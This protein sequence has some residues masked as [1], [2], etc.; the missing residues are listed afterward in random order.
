MQ[1]AQAADF[2]HLLLR[3][4][5]EHPALEQARGVRIGGIGEDSIRADDQGAAFGRI[6]DLDRLA[7]FFQQEQI[8]FVAV[9]HDGALAEREFFRR[10]GR[11]LHLQHVL[12]RELLEIGPAEI[13]RHLIRR[14]ENR[15]AI[16]RVPLHD[17]SVP[18][19]IEEVGK[20][21]RRFLGLH[22]RR[23]VADHAQPSAPG[24]E[25]P[26]RVPVFRRIMTRDI[27]G[28]VRREP[29]VALPH[30]EM[31][32][33]GGIH[34]IDRINSAA[35]FLADALKYALGARALDARGD[36]GIFRFERF[37]DLFRDRQ[38]YRGVPGDLAFLAGR[39]DQRGR[40]RTCL[41][42]CRLQRRGEGAERERRR[43]FQ[44]VPPGK[45]S[46]PH[47]RIL[48]IRSM[49]G[50]VPAANAARPPSPA[51][52]FAPPARPRAT[53]FRPRFRRH[54]RDGRRERL[55]E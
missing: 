15:S 24:R 8:I 42:R 46:V 41:G 12:L 35:V 16:A 52:Y 36:A 28:N 39:L 30:D 51:R 6:D 22:Q 43:P 13:A 34:D 44:Q 45:F 10:L 48:P 1:R 50:S 9:G 38:I 23:V 4:D 27:L 17:L 19:R 3:L 20:A 31:R 53:A 47:R 40:D 21:F 33:V 49:H 25:H 32:G 37:R 18:F 7:R 5:R 29:S 11:R 54:N 55:A 14:G 2:D 26:V